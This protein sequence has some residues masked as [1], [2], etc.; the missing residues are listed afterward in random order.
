MFIILHIARGDSGAFRVFF[1]L[2]D[3][4]I[5]TLEIGDAL[6]SASHVSFGLGETVFQGTVDAPGAFIAGKVIRESGPE[7]AL[8]FART[9]VSPDLPVTDE[10]IEDPDG[11]AGDFTGSIQSG[12][13]LEITI[14]LR[15]SAHGYV[16]TMDV[17]AQDVRGA[18]AASVQLV[19]SAITIDFGFA[20]YQGTFS[21]GR[22]AL[23]GTWRQGRRESALNLRRGDPAK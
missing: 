8:T 23:T 13:G 12:S 20:T 14:H 6:F 16:A 18:S 21:E 3:Q 19:G 2:P 15:R 11:I 10:A 17:P 1:D 7:T 9:A 4:N 5:R 22:D